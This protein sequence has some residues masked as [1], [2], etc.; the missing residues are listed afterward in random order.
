MKGRSLR[1]GCKLMIIVWLDQLVLLLV[2]VNMW[3]FFHFHG[4]EA[5]GKHDPDISYAI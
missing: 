4:S 3:G 2:L 1:I 5:L